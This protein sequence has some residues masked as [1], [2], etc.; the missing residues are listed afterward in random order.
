MR[1]LF[2][3]ISVNVLIAL[4]AAVI[5]HAQTD[6][7]MQSAIESKAYTFIAQSA[8]PQTGGIIRLTGGITYTLKV[9]G[10]TLVCDLPYYGRAYNATYGGDAGLKFTSVKFE[11][12]VKTKKKGRWDVHIRTK[13]LTT[14]RDLWLTIFENGSTTVNVSSSD[15][16]AINYQGDVVVKK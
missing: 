7:T 12:K 14:N 15:R 9:N 8:S 16:Q 6:V 11:H 3:F 13:D 1:L 10:D 4:S 5:V 2:R